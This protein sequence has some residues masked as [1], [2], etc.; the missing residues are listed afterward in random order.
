[1]RFYGL[2]KINRLSPPP[3]PS[4]GVYIIRDRYR[5]RVTN[6]TH[7]STMDIAAAAAEILMGLIGAVAEEPVPGWIITHQQQHYKEISVR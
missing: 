1:M 2:S 6:L 5:R 3:S 4:L 7:A